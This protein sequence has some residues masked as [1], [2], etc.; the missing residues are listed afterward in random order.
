MLAPGRSFA[1]YRIEGVVGRGGM[2]VVYRATQLSLDRTVALKVIAPELAED[3]RFR[4]RFL[5]ESRVA[6]GI[7]HPHILRVY[8]A[9]EENGALHF[10]TRYVEGEDLQARLKRVGR[11]DPEPA[12]ALLAQVAR[13]LDA[14]HAKGSCTGT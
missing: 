2:G 4:E 10:V 14:A 12:L 7:E 6:A 3:P 5:R 13:A 11:L 1:G 8:G 9:G